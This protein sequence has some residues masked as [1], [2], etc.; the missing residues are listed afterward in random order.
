MRVMKNL[1]SPPS[2]LFLPLLLA[3][4]TGL[5]S[6]DIVVTSFYNINDGSN[7]NV[8]GSIVQSGTLVAGDQGVEAFTMDFF[9]GN[10]PNGDLGFDLSSITLTSNGGDRRVNQRVEIFVRTAGSSEFV[11]L[12]AYDY[13]PNGG[14][15][16]TF[17]AQSTVHDNLGGLIAAGV[18][19]VRF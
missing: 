1:S 6:A 15:T 10:N 2:R 7:S 18:D 12:F 8:D 19:A 11:S 4:S 16:G 5:A 17:S 14:T 9:L 13:L 3:A